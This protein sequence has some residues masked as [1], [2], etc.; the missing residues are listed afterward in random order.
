MIL[1]CI[2]IL[3]LVWMWIWNREAT[4]E[5]A[6]RDEIKSLD[7]N[8]P[9]KAAA[10]VL[11]T[12]LADKPRKADELYQIGA[13]YDYHF[14][15]SE[16]AAAYYKSAIDTAMANEPRELPFL[17]DRVGDRLAVRPVEQDDYIQEL[18]AARALQQAYIDARVAVPVEAQ[19]VWHIDTQNVHDSALSNSVGT[20]YQQLK[21]M[22]EGIAPK[23]I[24]EII[25]QVPDVSARRM[26]AYIRDQNPTI[27]N[28][29]NDTETRF[30]QEVWKQS[31]QTGDQKTSF[32]ESLCEAWN[33]DHPVCI[34]GRVARVLSS[35]AHTIPDSQIGIL[36]TREAIRNEIFNSAAHIL[37]TEL[38][39][40]PALRNRWAQLEEDDTRVKA[41]RDKIDVMVEGYTDVPLVDREK[42]KT[43]CHSAL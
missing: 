19:G 28:L 1:L 11:G 22:N 13:L 41:V 5:T 40:D 27:V 29:N 18:D 24:N 4:R 3:V 25:E 8:G 17:M 21:L 9:T 20:Q 42:I 38:D 26:L 2:I 33:N 12:R 34:T 32:T 35:L 6:K 16:R 14:G 37:K 30:I 36:K 15:N 31:S 7:G 43:E 23:T 10:R 39:Q